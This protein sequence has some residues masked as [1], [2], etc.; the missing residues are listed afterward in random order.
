MVYAM[1]RFNPLVWEKIVENSLAAIYIH[2]RSGKI[3]YV[4]DIVTKATKYSKEE[5]YALPSILELAYPEDREKLKRMV[6]EVFEGKS[7]LYEGRYVRKDGKVRWAWGIATPIEIDGEI[8]ALG[9]W[10]DITRIK[11]LEEKL[12]ESEEFYRTLIEESLAVVYILQEGRLVYANKAFE[13]MTGYKVEEVLGKNPAFLVHP[14]D[15]EIV[16][17]RYVERERGLRPIETYSWRIITK[18]GKVKWITARP[19]R[20]IY[21]GKPAVAATALDTTEIHRLREQLENKNEYL[22]LLNRILRHDIANALTFVRFVLEETN[23]ELAKKALERIDYITDLLADVRSLETALDEVRPVR[24]D[25]LVAEV[26]ESFDNVELDLE[27][28]KVR[29]NEGLKTVVQN[30]IHNAITHGGGK[31]VVEVRR[32][33]GWG[34][35][36]VKDYGDGIPD[37]LKE[38]IFEEGFSTKSR[39]GLGL[40]IVRRLIEIYGGEIHVYDNEPRGSIFEVKLVAC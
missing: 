15:R 40:Y 34:I 39:S 1:V 24:L 20:I 14:E 9:N 19:N 17:R 27:E 2:D 26:A 36:R 3:V 6:E 7:V 35:L 33:Q 37:E 25:K 21:R 31:A 38:K 4:N 28:V 5:L 32:E 16:W 22:R 8:Y 13:D 18:R 10:V 30:L 23:S 29:A 12:R 11:E